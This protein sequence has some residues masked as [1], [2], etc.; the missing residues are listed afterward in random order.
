MMTEATV[1]LIE[2]LHNMRLDKDVDLLREIV[3]VVSEA[4]MELEVEQTT[5]AAKYE[6]SEQRTNQ[7]NGYG[8]RVWQTRV[9]EV[10]LTDYTSAKTSDTAAFAR[11]FQ[12]VLQ[13]GVYLAPSQFEA[14]FTSTAHGD[15][16]IDATIETAQGAFRA[17]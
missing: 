5:G 1:A 13:A 11:F 9:R 12:A 7:R 10:P 3:R 4:L 6:R 16:V 2:Y 17:A 15:D 8:G 14:G